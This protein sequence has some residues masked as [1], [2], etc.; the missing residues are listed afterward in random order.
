MDFRE[1]KA[2]PR[3]GRGSGNPEGFG[4]QEATAMIRE[5]KNV[6]VKKVRKGERR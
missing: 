3:R 2:S 5:L 1:Q 4:K 6:E